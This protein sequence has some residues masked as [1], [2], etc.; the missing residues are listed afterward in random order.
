MRTVSVNEMT[1]I[2]ALE[3]AAPSKPMRPGKVELRE[4]EYIRHGTKTLIAGFDVATGKVVATVGDTRTEED[5]VAF[6]KELFAGGEQQT[7]WEVVADNLNTH[8]SEGVVRL[9]A[10]LC[11][12]PDDLGVK[13]KSGILKSMD[14]RE[15]FLRDAS[16][17][18]TFHFTPYHASWLN[19]I[20]IWFSILVKKVI[21]RGNFTSKDELKEKI[22][23]FISFFNKTM[24]RPFS[25]TYK[26]KPLTA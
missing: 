9:I 21:K 17:R 26:G 6:L 11:A 10:D 8:R 2:Q 25:W 14:S 22:M 20:E 5:Y 12:V 13:G 4:Y 19:Q 18:I 15:K 16:H 23:E 24:A 7:G 3:R 1:G